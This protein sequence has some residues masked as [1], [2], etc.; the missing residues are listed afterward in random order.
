MIR[1]LDYE[2]VSK[3]ISFHRQRN[4]YPFPDLSS[5][6]YCAK[7][8]L[9]SDGKVIGAAFVHLTSE[10]SLIVDE[11]SSKLARART[12]SQFFSKMYQELQKF[13]LVDTHVF[14]VPETNEEFAQ[15]LIQN[16]K[17]SKVPGISLER[18]FQDGKD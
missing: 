1:D 9:I 15:F 13:G 7:K 3:I 18:V 17:F 2:D 11:N 6:L 10:I 4:L 5:P 16:F 8:A 12:I 14:V